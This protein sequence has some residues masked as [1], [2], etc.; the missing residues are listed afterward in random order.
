[1]SLLVSIKFLN[2]TVFLW[3]TTVGKF[4]G[5]SLARLFFQ[6]CVFQ[7]YLLLSTICM[8]FILCCFLSVIV[9]FPFN[10]GSVISK[11]YTYRTDN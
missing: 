8:I 11:P 5:K 10:I 2:Y 1:M 9:V 3:F 6:R 4:I 7:I